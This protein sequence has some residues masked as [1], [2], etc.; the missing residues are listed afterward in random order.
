MH[1]FH[2]TG[3][4]RSY[5]EGWYFKQQNEE[6]TVALIPAF[7]VNATGQ[8]SASLQV[9]TNEGSCYVSFPNRHFGQAA[10]GF[11]CIWATVFSRQTDV[12]CR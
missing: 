12:G 11:S 6:D 1:S 8:A 3:K 5:F 10:S 2:G 9:I 7:H 4:R